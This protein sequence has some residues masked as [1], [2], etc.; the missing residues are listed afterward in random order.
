MVLAQP[1]ED[2]CFAELLD[3]GPMILM[4]D[5]GQILGEPKADYFFLLLDE[6]DEVVEEHH[7]TVEED[8]L[9][10]DDAVYVE[11]SQGGTDR[12][13]AEYGWLLGCLQFLLYPDQAGVEVF[14]D[15]GW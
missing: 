9:D 7:Q 8:L 1:D 11:F 12:L 2:H 3:E 14:A 5:D 15:F 13:T 4:L 6:G 10:L